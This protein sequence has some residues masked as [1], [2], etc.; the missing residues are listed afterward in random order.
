MIDLPTALEVWDHQT[1]LA[2]AFL[3]DARGNHHVAGSEFLAAA[4][5]HAQLATAAA[6]VAAALAQPRARELLAEA[7]MSRD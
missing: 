1:E 6:T 7:V 5:V 2:E 3:D 4:A